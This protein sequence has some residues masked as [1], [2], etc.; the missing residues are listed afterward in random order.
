MKTHFKEKRTTNLKEISKNIKKFYET[1]Y[2]QNSSKTN[3]KKQ[4]LLNTLNSKALTNQRS[5]LCKIEIREPDL[6]DSMKC[7]D[8]QQIP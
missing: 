3:V 7:Y 4:K 6:F 8:Q 2:K 1:V 5:D